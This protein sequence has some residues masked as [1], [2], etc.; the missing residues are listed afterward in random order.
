MLLYAHGIGRTH[1]VVTLHMRHVIGVRA[2]LKTK[3]K[4][5]TCAIQL[6]WRVSSEDLTKIEHAPTAGGA[7]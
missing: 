4:V 7:M 5:V 1:M 2:Y 6:A 3:I